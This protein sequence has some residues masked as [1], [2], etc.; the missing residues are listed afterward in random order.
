MV[1]VLNLLA[2]YVCIVSFI[3]PVF[4][5][6]ITCLE[7]IYQQKIQAEVTC[8]SNCLI[9]AYSGLMLLKIILLPLILTIQWCDKKM[10]KTVIQLVCTHRARLTHIQ[11]VQK[12]LD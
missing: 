1:V 12:A 11:H 4:L 5:S 8:L 3:I 2:T 10:K 6:K 9:Y 7:M